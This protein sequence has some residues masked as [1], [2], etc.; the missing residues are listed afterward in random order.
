MLWIIFE[1]LFY[2]KP[3]HFTDIA[4]N[5]DA[6]NERRWNKTRQM[7]G[8]EF[9][10]FFFIKKLKREDTKQWTNLPI[11]F[12]LVEMMKNSQ[13]NIYTNENLF[14]ASI[15]GYLSLNRKKEWKKRKMNLYHLR[16]KSFELKASRNGNQQTISIR[17]VVSAMFVIRNLE[18][19]NE[20]TNREEQMLSWKL[21]ILNY[22]H[23]TN[24]GQLASFF[25]ALSSGSVSRE[26]V[27]F[28][29]LFYLS[30]GNICK[31]SCH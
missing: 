17:I 30:S 22:D 8:T 18:T 1:F 14:D 21:L 27:L 2:W 19:I 29:L 26:M 31:S 20:G 15:Y 7:N 6:D 3:L 16:Q 10:F 23:W 28:S 9:F 4:I 13:A 5:I 24:D 11:E 12:Y 25:F